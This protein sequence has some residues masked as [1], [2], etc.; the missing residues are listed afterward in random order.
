MAIIQQ[1]TQ[2]ESSWDL[3]GALVDPANIAEGTSCILVGGRSGRRAGFTLGAL[4]GMESGDGRVWKHCWTLVGTQS[5]FAHTGDSGAAVVVE[6]TGELLGHLVGTLGQLR[7]GGRQ[8]G[9]VQDATTTID[10]LT[11]RGV[12]IGFLAESPRV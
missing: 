3:D 7:R 4:R 1:A 6:S 9:I 2:V 8:V 11:H 12:A 10:H 5:T